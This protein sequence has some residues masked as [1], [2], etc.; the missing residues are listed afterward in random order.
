MADIAYSID[1]ANDPDEDVS[2]AFD[3]PELAID[4][5]LPVTTMS[6]RDRHAPPL[7]VAEELLA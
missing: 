1:R 2:I 3:V 7:A 6:D 4:W 5:P